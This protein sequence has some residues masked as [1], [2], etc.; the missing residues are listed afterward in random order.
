[1]TTYFVTRHAGARG[2]AARQGLDAVQLEHL[3]PGHIVAGDVVIG[4]LPVHLVADIQRRGAC[5]LHLELTIP[6]EHRGRD[7]S[8]DD[9]ERFG[10]RLV[11][12]R[13]RRVRPR[14]D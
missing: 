1:M 4:T 6:P 9:M 3:D 12:Y 14:S 2:W 8:A 13:V 7:L 11:E 10:A 5:Y